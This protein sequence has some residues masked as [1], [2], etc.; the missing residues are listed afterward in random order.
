MPSNGHLRTLLQGATESGAQ[1][2][3]VRRTSRTKN[4]EIKDCTQTKHE[5]NV[6][7]AEENTWDRPS[8]SSHKPLFSLKATTALLPT[9]NDGLL[10]TR[11]STPSFWSKYPT[12]GTLEQSRH[13]FSW[14]PHRRP[15][16][17]PESQQTVLPNK[18]L[19]CQSQFFVFS[20]LQLC[21]Q[22]PILI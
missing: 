2:T 20:L 18:L 4:C 10:G 19:C 22:E 12:P 21:T 6:V 16:S 5:L 3:L 15:P 8:I 11:C 13:P 1:H 7:A 17:F 14:N 9:C